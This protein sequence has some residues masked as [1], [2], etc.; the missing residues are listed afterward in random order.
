MPRNSSDPANVEYWGTLFGFTLFSISGVVLHILLIC[1][2]R[3]SVIKEN[4]CIFIVN[5]S[6]N[7]IS[8]CIVY[9]LQVLNHFVPHN[10]Y[11]CHVLSFG[12]CLFAVNMFCCLPLLSFCRYIVLYHSGYY[13]HWFSKR[14]CVTYCLLT[15]I[16]CIMVSIGTVLGEMNGLIVHENDIMFCH[17]LLSIDTIV[18]KMTVASGQILAGLC[19]VALGYFNFNI[20]QQI[21]A[22]VQNA[23]KMIEKGNSGEI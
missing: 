17:C 20:P 21:K 10:D 2:C 8:L 9:L 13:P 14:A 18:A 7:D 1:F 5:L 3:K 15:W 22:M 12:L 6:I 4:Y 16:C 11:F 23:E 19:Y